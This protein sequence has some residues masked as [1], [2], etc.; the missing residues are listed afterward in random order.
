MNIEV[1]IKIKV[2][3]LEGL[4]KELPKFGK[5]TKS[6]RQI[7]D[8]YIPCHRNFFERKP[9]PNEW[10][11]IRHNPDCVIFEYDRSIDSAD[12]SQLYA[13][14][15][16]TKISE[17]EEF[18]KILGFL[19]FKKV[20]TVDKKREYWDCEKFEVCLDE[21]ENLGFFVEIEAKGDF[22][23]NS[24]AM[25]ECEKFAEKL[26]IKITKENRIKTGY[27]VL[28]LKKENYNYDKN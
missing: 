11:R 20:M 7:D 13:E 5:I 10:L 28:L 14:E 18:K 9:D 15:Y 19:D 3:N 27:P 23:G 2:E 6:I 22:K 24:E 17:P 8:Y 16:E 21:V 1:E 4:K 12:G 26:G 25:R